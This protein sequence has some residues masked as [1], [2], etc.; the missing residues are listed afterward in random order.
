VVTAQALGRKSNIACDGEREES[1][2]IT[3]QE[4]Q[5]KEVVERRECHAGKDLL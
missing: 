2:G 5:G 4:K 1:L 3:G